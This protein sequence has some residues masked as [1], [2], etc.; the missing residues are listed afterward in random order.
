MKSA[1][2]LRLV[3]AVFLASTFISSCAPALTVRYTTKP[4]VQLGLSGFQVSYPQGESSIA[5]A[6]FQSLNVQLT[7]A[8]AAVSGNVQCREDMD[9]WRAIGEIRSNIVRFDSNL[10][11]VKSASAQL[12][13]QVSV[14]RRDGQ[15]S[16]VAI[17][18]AA[19]SRVDASNPAGMNKLRSDLTDQIATRVFAD[20]APRTHFDNIVFDDEDIY[21][22]GI[23]QALN[24]N[25]IGAENFFGDL[26]RQNNQ[27]A[28]AHYNL[29]VIA[30]ARGDYAQAM[31][32][33]EAAL[34]L[35]GS[36]LY[37]DTIDEFRQ[38]Q[39]LTR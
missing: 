16:H 5:N 25:L 1:N 35:S 17:Y 8:N 23:K 11:D 36:S 29:G 26:L 34:A 22:P 12:D 9:C 21:E 30:E 15:T 19:V 33:Y 3:S 2:R 38:R 13:A 37:R 28:G 27:L 31:Q 6:L 7:V 32:R 24:G 18:S 4:V 14:I 39:A 20:V 10:S